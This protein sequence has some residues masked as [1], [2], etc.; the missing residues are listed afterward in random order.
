MNLPKF[1]VKV[2]AYC[3]NSV[4]VEVEAQDAQSAGTAAVDWARTNWEGAQ[5]KLEAT[6]ITPSVPLEKPP[7]S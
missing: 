1:K 2:V 6:E 3:A 7:E 5:A 4:E